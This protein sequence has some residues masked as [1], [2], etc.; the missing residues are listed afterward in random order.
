MTYYLEDI[1][2]ERCQYF[3]K[4]IINEK[5]YNA[6]DDFLL[7]NCDLFNKELIID[8]LDYLKDDDILRLKNM[9]KL[10]YQDT[11]IIF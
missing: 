6:F 7:S 1:H 5:N 2:Y 3:D 8:V 10:N 4:E 11:E 9:I